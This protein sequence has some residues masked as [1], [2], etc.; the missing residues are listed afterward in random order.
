MAICEYCGEEIEYRYI[1]GVCT[2]I[3]VNGNWC[4]NRS[5]LS[6]SEKVEKGNDSYEDFCRLTT[7]NRCWE[8][9]YFIRHNGGSVWVDELEWPWPKHGCMYNHEEPKYKEPRWLGYLKKHIPSETKQHY[10]HGIVVRSIRHSGSPSR[11]ILAIDGGKQGKLIL[12]TEANTSVSYLFRELVFVNFRGSHIV[13][14]THDI[15][16]MFD[17]DLSPTLVGLPHNWPTIHKSNN[18]YP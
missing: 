3:H 6:Y 17:W 11:I 1:N 4:S 5:E 12:A 16:P 2:P 13:I 15:K 10:F 18:H 7:C 8:S 9:V 14:S